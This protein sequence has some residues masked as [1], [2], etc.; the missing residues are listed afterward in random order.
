[1]KVALEVWG[2][3]YEQV[4]STCLLA[5]SLGLD[6][7]YYGEA[8]HDLNLDCWTTLAGLARATE[9]IRLG[10]VITNILPTYRSPVLLAKQVATVAAMSNGRLDFRTGVGASASF[11]RQ[12][13]EPFGI[14]YPDY[15]QRLTDLEH[16]L[17]TLPR[18]WSGDALS[19]DPPIPTGL[20]SPYD[21]PV[22]IAATGDRAMTL[23][24]AHA[25]VWET[26]FCTPAEFS[27][28]AARLADLCDGRHV[29]RSLEIDGFVARSASALGR[30]L[31]RVRSERSTT[32]DLDHILARALVG[33]PADAAH[34]LRELEA[35]GVDQVVVALHDPHDKDALEAV[36]ETAELIR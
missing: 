2:S 18:R 26:S 32:E 35:A 29:V 22:T 23:A 24:A 17:K 16:A 27:E 15:T 3:S 28:R 25:D 5:E 11:G 9:R 20:A 21:V 19:A 31:D 7:L 4:E 12:W 14:E 13:W 10:P 30:L 6:G 33:V 36:A 8:P 34:R 1:M